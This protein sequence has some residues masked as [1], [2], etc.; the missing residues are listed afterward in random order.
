MADNQYW[1]Y[2]L[3]NYP[4]SFILLAPVPQGWE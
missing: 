2:A 1:L 4:H 3:L